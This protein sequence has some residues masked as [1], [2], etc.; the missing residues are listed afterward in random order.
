VRVNQR[1]VLVSPD[2]PAEPAATGYGLYA[3]VSSHD[4]KP[5]LDRQVARLTG[6]AADAGGRVVR[7]EAEV[8]SGM[9]GSRAKVRRLLADPKVTTV[10]VEHRDRL[11]RMNTELAESALSAHGR[12]LVVLDDGEVDDDLIRDMVEVLTWFCARLYGRR[13][14]RNRALK[15]VG[16]AQRGI[17]PQAIVSAGRQ[18]AGHE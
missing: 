18:D 17:G 3:R 12:R 1:T 10:V 6:W 2:T 4:Q 14:A 16:C 15:A 9:N 13:S 5:D 7:V 8:G 11:G